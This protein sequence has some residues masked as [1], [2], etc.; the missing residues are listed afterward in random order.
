MILRTAMIGLKEVVRR[1][2][3][4]ASTAGA[5]GLLVA[6]QVFLWGLLDGLTVSTTGA[7]RALGADVI[8]YGPASRASLLR[9]RLPSGLRER[10]ESVQGVGSTAGLGV[11][12]AWGR[13][14]GSQ[15]ALDL[16]VFGYEAG[17][18]RVP[19]PPP[20]GSAYADRSLQE[21]GVRTG[22]VIE[23]GRDRISLRVAGWVDATS[24]LG[25]PA[26]WVDDETWREVLATAAPD[27]VLP[28]AVWQALLVEVAG[29]AGDDAGAVASRIVRR[30]RAEAYPLEV[31]IS[32][33]P[34]VE[35]QRAS[36]LQLIGATTLVVAL[37]VALFFALVT[38][39][40]VRLFGVLKAMGISS[41]G[42][43]GSLVIQALAL[44]GAAYLLGVAGAV[45]LARAA[46]AEIPILLDPSRIL[47]VGPVLVG[48]ALVG[49]A[50]SFRRVVRIDPA[51]AV[52][53]R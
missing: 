37:V 21:E 1:P 11:A 17:V 46:P 44:T 39:E 53:G 42:L 49:V 10:V 25:Q 31:A 8:V 6:L 18:G 35:A 27:R 16:A 51:T 24:Y 28:D 22:D 40:R 14:E 45:G 20:R 48:T 34:G 9:S 19:P 32:R 13:V 30:T 50:S 4:F 3:R 29:E 43:L 5:L 26:L 33:L 38:L 15:R 36:F 12:L 47:S 7:Y 41:L 2:G 23:V 52:V